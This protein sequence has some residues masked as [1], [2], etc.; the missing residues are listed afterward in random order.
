MYNRVIYV[1]TVYMYNRVIY[2]FTV[3]MY[4]R[5]ICVCIVYIWRYQLAVF[6]RTFLCS[7]CKFLCIKFH[8]LVHA[9]VYIYG[10]Q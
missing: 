1:L 10:D 5:V 4:N 8:S 3:Y 2:V 7:M 9:Y 6:T